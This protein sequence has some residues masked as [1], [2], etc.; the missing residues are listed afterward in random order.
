MK[1]ISGKRLGKIVYVKRRINVYRSLR[2]AYIAGISAA[3]FSEKLN[4]VAQM[5]PPLIFTAS[6]LSSCSVS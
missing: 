3:I 2:R 6:K 5:T 4:R 1:G